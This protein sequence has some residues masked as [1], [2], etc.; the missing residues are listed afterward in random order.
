MVTSG[1]AASATC[2]PNGKF[3]LQAPTSAAVP[4]VVRKKA[5]RLSP[6]RALDPMSLVVV[7]DVDCPFDQSRCSRRPLVRVFRRPKNKKAVAPGARKRLP[8]GRRRCLSGPRSGLAAPSAATA[9]LSILFTSFV[10]SWTWAEHL[11]YFNRL[12]R[13]SGTG[14]DAGPSRC[15][16]LQAQSCKIFVHCK[17]HAGD[18]GLHVRDGSPSSRGARRCCWDRRPGRQRHRCRRLARPLHQ[19]LRPGRRIVKIGPEDRLRGG[20][21]SR[22]TSAPGPSAPS[23]HRATPPAPGSGRAAPLRP[24]SR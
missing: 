22:P 7:I 12:A 17:N 2:T 1:P 5:R 20:E 6:R 9:S 24:T 14:T 4:A 11:N 10:P 23:A 3:R 13:M 16:P 8:P 19:R 15:C 21:Q 18:G